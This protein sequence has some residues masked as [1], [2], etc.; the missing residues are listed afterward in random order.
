M[1]TQRKD[2]I[3]TTLSIGYFAGVSSCFVAYP[4]DTVRYSNKCTSSE[5]DNRSRRYV[6]STNPKQTVFMTAKDIVR[7]EGFFSLFKGANYITG[8][9]GGCA[10]A[11]YDQLHILANNRRA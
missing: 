4:L 9:S 11:L 7:R 3:F 1:P 6:M 10:L 2:G 5:S 8:I